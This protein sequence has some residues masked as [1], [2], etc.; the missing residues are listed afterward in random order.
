MEDS[1]DFVPPTS[2]LAPAIMA[3][4]AVNIIIVAYVVKAFRWYKI[5]CPTHNII[6]AE[7]VKNN[8]LYYIMCYTFRLLGK[9]NYK[10][11]TRLSDVELFLTFVHLLICDFWDLF[12]SNKYSPQCFLWQWQQCALWKAC[13]PLLYSRDARAKKPVK[14]MRKSATPPLV[15]RVIE[16]VPGKRIFGLYRFQHFSLERH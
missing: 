11:R 8:T 2:V 12:F 1:F 13:N 9:S 4:A 7:I 10:K 15:H 3:V 16:A 14:T 5:P 6:W